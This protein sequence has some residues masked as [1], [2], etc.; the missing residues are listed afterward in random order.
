ME[1]F[2]KRSNK[3]SKLRKTLRKIDFLGEQPSL[4]INGEERYKTLAGAFCSILVI[5]STLLTTIFFFNK[6]WDKTD[7]GINSVIINGNETFSVDLKKENFYIFLAPIGGPSLYGHW[8]NLM[9]VWAQVKVK[10]F[11]KDSAGNVINVNF[12]KHKL[13][14]ADCP[15]YEGHYEFL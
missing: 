1:K 15:G 9:T 10:T 6:F 3:T 7:P 2:K 8:R 4:K 12:Q 11:V 13:I 14:A 5:L